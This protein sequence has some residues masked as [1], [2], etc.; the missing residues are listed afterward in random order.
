[1]T[2]SQM[3]SGMLVLDKPAGITSR[4]AVNRIQ[5]LAR[6]LR[7]G[8]A[9]TLD[10]PATG[11]LLVCIGD[12]T[13]LVR[14]LQLLPKTYLARFTL[15]QSSDTDDAA[16]Q[17]QQHP[18]PDPLPTLTS[19]SNCLQ[20]FIG[21]IAQTPPAWSAVHVNGQRAYDLARAGR[22]FTLSARD[23]DVHEISI[24]SWTWPHLDL[25][26]S[27]GSGTYIRSIARDLG[28]NLGCGAL[29]SSLQRTAVGPW[30]LSQA[31]SPDSLS[32]DTLQ[33]YIINPARLVDHLPVYPCTESE[34]E[35]IRCGRRIPC[36][37]DRLVLPAQPTEDPSIALKSADMQQL[38]A[39]AE[40]DS[41]GLLQP[42]A[43]FLHGPAVN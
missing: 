19:I 28:Q 25:E 42:R 24:R 4:D 22:E 26:I 5:R 29:M 38:L 17:I 32:L 27:C 37:P 15:G 13:R 11:I 41:T 21:T 7:T 43:V 36:S 14:I 33:Q 18:A 12:A 16:G 40:P 23:V 3:C 20:Q 1:M 39:L 34:R 31:V 9:G 35:D 8:H 6:P 30:D 2:P 10:P